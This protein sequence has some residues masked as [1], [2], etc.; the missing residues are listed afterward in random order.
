MGIVGE[1]L[2]YC[3]DSIQLWYLDKV[4]EPVPNSIFSVVMDEEVQRLNNT[5]DREI[6]PADTHMSLSQVCGVLWRN[7]ELS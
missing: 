1:L 2:A 7:R 5:C 6:D 4:A 3:A